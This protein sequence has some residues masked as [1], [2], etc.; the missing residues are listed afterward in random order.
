MLGGDSDDDDQPNTYDY[1]DSFIDD[2][3]KG[4]CVK[5][6]GGGGHEFV[7][8]G[9]WVCVEEGPLGVVWRSPAMTW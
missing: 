8:R 5:G 1:N 3:E 7:W 6:G 4:M 2:E 9:P